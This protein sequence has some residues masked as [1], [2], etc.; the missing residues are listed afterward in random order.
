MG[1]EPRAVGQVHSP[2]GNVVDGCEAVRHGRGGRD[3]AETRSAAGQAAVRRG[4]GH[5]GARAAADAAEQFF[6]EALFL[7]RLGPGDGGAAGSGRAAAGRCDFRG[8]LVGLRRRRDARSW[9]RREID[10]PT[11]RQRREVFLRLGHGEVE[12][13]R[14]RGG[15]RLRRRQRTLDVGEAPAQVCHLRA[16]DGRRR[17]EAGRRN[18]FEREGGRPA[19]E[20]VIGVEQFRA[21]AQADAGHERRELFGRFERGSVSVWLRLQHLCAN[22]AEKGDGDGRADEARHGAPPAAP[23][24]EPD[25]VGFFEAVRIRLHANHASATRALYLH[26]LSRRWRALATTRSTRRMFWMARVSR[27]GPF[28]QC[29]AIEA[30]FG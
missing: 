9:R 4:I 27:A 20:R 19:A 24:R 12:R 18:R 30:F 14:N 15:G 8:L 11:R 10:R 2:G 13:A 16:G 25:V 3:A 28:V 23:L 29:R 21:G 1:L 5:G 6:E 22:T 7:G 17:L 26:S